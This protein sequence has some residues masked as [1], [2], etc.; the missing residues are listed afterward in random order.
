[1]K[2]NFTLVYTVL[3]IVGDFLALVGAFSAAYILRFKLDDQSPVA[4]ISA[5]NYIQAFLIVLPLWIL[6]HGFIGLY[7]REVYENRFAEFGKLIIGSLLGILVVIG[8]DFISPDI[9]LQGRLVAGYGLALGFGFLLLFR[10][11]ARWLRI[12]LFSYGLGVN[13]LLVVGNGTSARAIIAQLRDTRHSGYRIVGVVGKT[14][15]AGVP[16]FSDFAAATKHLPNLHSIIQ[17][18]LYHEDSQNTEI[19]DYAQSHHISYR[20]IPGN[21]ELFT[22]N[23]EVELFRGTPVVTV[24]QTALIGWGRVVKRL[25][26]LAIAMVLLCLLA[27]LLVL[28]T[29]VIKIFE[30]RA[31]IF[32]RQTRL[33]RFNSPFQV[34]KFRTHITNYSGLSPELAFAKMGRPELLLAYRANGDYLPGDPRVS[35]V[36][37][38]LRRASLDEL[39]QLFNVMAGDL[40]LVGP[41][42]LVPDE[43]DTHAKKHAILSVK[44]GITGLAQISGRKDI[45]FEQRRKLDVYYVQNWSF[46]LDIII[47]LKTFRVVLGG[48]GAK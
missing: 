4:Q 41:R 2:N 24:H 1:M 5:T 17:T 13:D 42:A 25:F 39:P 26:D 32:F 9:L 33:T 27:P 23:L 40:S 7:R 18:K 44:S 10:S 37:R 45:D 29:V 48:R 22:G 46:W 19:L 16:E 20:F 35:R 43:I 14:P 12:M 31:P 21:S 3:L 11:V 36:G 28:V 47:L 38:F 8:Y 34:F 15:D 6:V 30:P